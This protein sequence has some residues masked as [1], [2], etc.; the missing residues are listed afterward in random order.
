MDQEQDTTDTGTAKEAEAPEPEARD[1]DQGEREGVAEEPQVST[2][3]AP[4][5]RAYRFTGSGAIREDAQSVP[6]VDAFCTRLRRLGA[7]DDEVEAFRRVWDEDEGW[8]IPKRDLLALPDSSL[9]QLIVGARDEYHRHTHTPAEDT[10]AAT[11]QA[12]AEW[13]KLNEGSHRANMAAISEWVGT[14]PLRARIALDAEQASTEP[15]KTLMAFLE[16]LAG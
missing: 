1:A 15:R 13:A 14:D 16:G 4:Q 11:E 6:P 7:T 12:E 9:R 8:V 10:V 5:R 3:S 2:G